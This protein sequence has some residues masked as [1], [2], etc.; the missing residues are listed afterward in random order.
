MSPKKVY[1]AMIGVFVLLSIMTVATVGYGNDLLQKKGDEL[2]QQKL[3]NA[4]LESQQLALARAKSDIRK[5]EQQEEVA[6]NI[7]P[8]EK[9]QAHTINELVALSRAANVQLSNI[10]FPSSNLGQVAPRPAATPSE[11]GETPAAA[12]PKPPSETQVT[13]VKGL[14]DVYQLDVTIQSDNSRPSRYTD[15]LN[16]LSMLESRPFIGQVSSVT[17]QPTSDDRSQVNFTIILSVYIKQ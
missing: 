12:A 8:R 15:L 4:T 14:K 1:F 7:V 6:K 3:D 5:Y 11:D 17:I 16:F 9:N 13:P 2:M 10:S